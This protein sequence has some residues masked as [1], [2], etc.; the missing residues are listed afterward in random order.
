[1]T[2]S[3]AKAADKSWEKAGN[4]SRCGNISPTGAHCD[5]AAIAKGL[6]FAHYQRQRR[7][8]KHLHR[9]VSAYGDAGKERISEFYVAR[10]VYKSLVETAK[11]DDTSVYQLLSKIIAF[12]C[13]RYADNIQGAVEVLLDLEL[14]SVPG[15]SALVKLPAGPRPTPAVMAWVDQV[16]MVSGLAPSQIAKRIVDYWHLEWSKPAA[17]RRKRQ[18]T[19]RTA[20]AKRTQR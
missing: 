3:S 9:E 5:K 7:G 20:R 11:R 17:T 13:E 4:A 15:K 16:A 2:N 10:P 6:C 18:A 8:S 1:M 14:I 12:H 19:R